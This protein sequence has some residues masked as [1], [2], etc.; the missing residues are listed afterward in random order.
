MPDFFARLCNS[1]CEIYLK[2]LA[3]DLD[4]G[5]KVRLYDKNGFF[6]LGEVREFENGKAIK[7]IKKFRID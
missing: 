3:L 7:P 1:G 6:S 2:K 4:L 5:E